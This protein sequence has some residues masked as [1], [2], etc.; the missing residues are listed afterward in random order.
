MPVVVLEMIALIFEVVE[1]L[2][3]KFPSTPPPTNQ[4]LDIV[5]GE[6]DIGDPAV[7]VLD[8]QLAVFS[9]RQNLELE[10]I[11]A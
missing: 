5:A 11:H 9:R 4:V 6:G 7:L 3:F 8:L 2:V 1:A 10:I